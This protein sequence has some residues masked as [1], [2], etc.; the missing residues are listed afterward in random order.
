MTAIDPDTYDGDGEAGKVFLSYTRRDRERT[1]RIAEVLR[2]RH[3]GVFKDTDDILPTEEWKTRLE[4]LIAEADTIV[5]LLSPN[6]VASEVCAWEVEYATS[7]N[8]R[9]APIVIDEVDTAKIPPLLARLNFIF[10]TE[11]DRFEDAVDSLVSALGTDI[12]WIREHTRLGGLAQRW[13]QAGRPARLLLRGQD[14]ADAEA[15]R[16]G[17]PPEAPDVTAL[18]AAFIGDSRKGASRR[19]RQIVAAS[20]AAVVVAVGLA[21]LAYWQREIADSERNSALR[22]QSRYLA[23]LSQE[24]AQQGDHTAAA[25]LALEALPSPENPRPYAAEAFAALNEATA[26]FGEFAIMAHKHFVNDAIWMPDRAGIV[27]FSGGDEGHF[28]SWHGKHLKTLPTGT[29]VRIGDIISRGGKVT[30]FAGDS[31]GFVY[32]IDPVSKTLTRSQQNRFAINDIKL[33][34]PHE[35]VRFH[36]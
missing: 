22:Q 21:G 6:S 34:S 19:Q 27:T 25:L 14:I 32:Q 28:W 10:C 33:I 29:N 18:Q 4:Q 30:A 1:Q 17:H 35:V 36:C 5:F 24:K 2:E 13:H 8:K 11:R 9:I 7:L 3:F 15:W 23:D 31:F 26:H 12:E 20:L 16:D